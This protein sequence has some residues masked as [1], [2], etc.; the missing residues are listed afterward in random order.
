MER[1]NEHKCR[2]CGEVFVVRYDA[3]PDDK[4]LEW[5]DVRCPYCHWLGRAPIAGS[6]EGVFSVKKTES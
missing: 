2:E 4:T 6:T 5:V 1:R 3:R